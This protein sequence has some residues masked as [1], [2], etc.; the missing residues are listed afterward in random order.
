[1]NMFILI[2]V[3]SLSCIASVDAMAKK[4][5]KVV[6]PQPATQQVDTPQA[7]SSTTEHVVPVEATQQQVHTAVTHQHVHTAVTQPTA[8]ESPVIAPAASAQV[9]QDQAGEPIHSAIDFQNGLSKLAEK[10]L[11]GVVN[12]STTQVINGR[13]AMAPGGEMPRMA[14]G[15]PFDDLFR[16]FF[17][18]ME[19]APRK[20]QSLGSGFITKIQGDKAFVVTNYH[21]VAEAKKITVTLNNRVELEATLHGR[22]ERTD[23]AVLAVDISK[24]AT[25]KRPIAL[26]WSVAQST[27]VGHFVAAIGNAFGLGNTLTFGV[28]SFK[29]RDL[30]ARKHD[31][32]DDFIQHTAPINMGNSGGPL[33]NM[34]GKVTG[35]NTAIFTPTGGHVGI[36]F[37]IPS[38]L[39]R[40]TVDALIE[41]G[42]VRRGWLGL[43]IQAVENVQKTDTAERMIIVGSVKDDS[44]CKGILQRG[45]F[46][47]KFNGITLD[48][49]NKLTRLVGET[50]PGTSV[51]LEISRKGENKSRTV[52]VVVGESPEAPKAEATPHVTQETG[53]KTE[54]VSI[55]L[56][57]MTVRE[58]ADKRGLVIEKLDELSPARDVGLQPRDVITEANRMDVKSVADLNKAL[59]A[60]QDSQGQTILMCI[61]RGNVNGMIMKGP[62]TAPARAGNN[63]PPEDEGIFFVSVK[64]YTEEMKKSLEGDSSKTADTPPVAAAQG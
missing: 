13:S 16:E 33:L 32:V 12:I 43:N 46:I 56:L 53:K 7:A 11:G 24:V 57:G 14:P 59:K 49:D 8:V 38:E 44:P 21:V 19:Q 1:M 17:G 62:E 22:D 34:D 4:P 42:R 52:T 18:Q 15:S 30:M 45:D 9:V 39:A 40:K 3:T 36:G 26:D 2:F 27:R 55:P 61:R 60:V 41:H 51:T 28:I 25:G 23:L 58:G 37:S 50:V 20:V 31:Y 5:N 63:T 64:L 10:T 48:Y 6:E 54:A 35:I 47:L 29:G